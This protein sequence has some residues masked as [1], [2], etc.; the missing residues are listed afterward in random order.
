M[1]QPTQTK[2]L[3]QFVVSGAAIILGIF[4]ASSFV[5]G[6]RMEQLESTL[7]V[8]LAEQKALLA[9]IAETT[10]RNGADSVTES[11]VRD[12]ALEDRS[13][14]DSLLG[15]LDSGLQR[16]ELIELEQ[17]FGVCG[18]FF[19]ERKAVM[20][21]RL[22]REIEV[23]EAYVAQ[24]STVTGVDQSKS[25]TLDQWRTLSEGEQ[26]QS[27]LFTQLVRLQK[28]IIDELLAGR[29]ANSEEIT[30]I[31]NEVRETREALLLTKTQTDTLR[32]DLTS[33]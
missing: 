6:E 16:S 30:A 23:Y 20:V 4:L 17:L 1:S 7:Q 26:T 33:L 29:A 2:K 25:Q 18:S 21:A 19:S 8:Q 14:F 10:A 27:V 13:R 32:G 12:C 24:L 9:T 28:D 31:L 11:I 22:A 5:V 3:V 15:Q